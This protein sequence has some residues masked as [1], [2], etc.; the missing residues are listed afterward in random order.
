MRLEELQLINEEDSKEPDGTYAAVSFSEDTKDRIKKFIDDN[1]IPNPIK[2]D[3]LHSTLLYSK[4]YCPNYEPLGEL[5][6]A[7]VGTPTEFDVWQSQPDDEGTCSNCL[8]L[9]FD[10][11]QLIDRHNSLMKEHGATFDFDEYRPHVTLSYDIGDLDIKQ[12]DPSSI[13][14]LNIIEEYGEDLNTD[15]AKENTESE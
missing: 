9:Q 15:W 7:L 13:G 1:E 2:L 8:V 3:K 5:E 14:D 11:D 6:E 12:L 10:C 4:K